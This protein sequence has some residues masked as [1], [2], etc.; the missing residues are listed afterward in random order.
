M[1]TIK[2]NNLA[3][4]IMYCMY[5]LVLLSFGFLST[6]CTLLPADE[7]TYLWSKDSSSLYVSSL[8]EGFESG[9]IPDIWGFEGFAPWLITPISHT[10]NFSIQSGSI[11]YFSYTTLKLKVR[12]PNSGFIDFYIDV[13]STPGS[14]LNLSI[15]SSMIGEWS[16]AWWTHVVVPLGPGDHLLTWKFS[17]QD[18]VGAPALIDDIVLTSN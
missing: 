4:L 2:K 17:T 15:D 10:G 16:S 5:L 3:E 14:S 1:M 12:I 13:S 6:T 9:Q 7:R 8:T 18:W 11:S